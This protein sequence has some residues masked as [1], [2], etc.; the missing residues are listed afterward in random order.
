M[1]VLVITGDHLRHL[2]LVHA[3]VGT[4][5]VAG[6]ILME[7]EPVVES[8][9]WIE[10]SHDRALMERHFHTRRAV[11]ESSFGAY[12]SLE[13]DF[14]GLI[15]RCTSEALNS[16]S[17]ARFVSE[18]KPDSAIVFG[19][20]LICDPLLGVLPPLSYNVHLGLSPHYRG[21]ATLFWP[22][23]FLQPQFCGATV[24]KLSAVVDGGD[25]LHQSLPDIRTGDGIH[26]VG[27]RTVQSAIND[28]VSIFERGLLESACQPQVQSGKVFRV[29]DFRPEHLRVI[30]DLFDDKI[31]DLFYSSDL[32]RSVRATTVDVLSKAE[33]D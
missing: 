8:F 19:S 17:T 9:A 1:R 27:V 28:L 7:R 12:R 10:D 6:W 26:D 24:H 33:S 22:Y 2:G 5:D 13:Q 32:G 16:Q 25:V 15:L 3:L 21:S 18:T 4:V 23:Y 29:A 11:E 30:Y 14:P 31:A 20:D